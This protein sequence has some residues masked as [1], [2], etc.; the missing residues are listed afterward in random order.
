MNSV[1][2]ITV[3]KNNWLSVWYLYT[4]NSNVI[5]KFHLHDSSFICFNF[6]SNYN[7]FLVNVLYN[8]VGK[9]SVYFSKHGCVLDVKNKVFW[10]WKTWRTVIKHCSVYYVSVKEGELQTLWV[11]RVQVNVVWNMFSCFR[12]GGLE[13]NVVRNC[14]LVFAVVVYK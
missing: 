12:C 13:V 2:I 4:S 14:S 3:F 6:V 5:F 1:N 11:N 7:W 10:M 9:L 8:C